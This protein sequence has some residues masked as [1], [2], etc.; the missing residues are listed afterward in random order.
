[1]ALYQ[2]F[3]GQSSFLVGVMESSDELYAAAA[4]L[5]MD[6]Q[7]FFSYSS[8]MTDEIIL[9]CIIHASNVTR[10][11]YPAMSES[12]TLAESFLTMLPSLNPLSAHAIVSSV[13]VLIEFLESSH[14][15]RA[16]AVQKYQIS[17]ES[18]SLLNACF[19]Y[20][21]R[22]DC[23]SGTTEC[24][25]SVSSAPDSDSCP[26]KSASEMRKRK[27]IQ[28]TL[29]V[30][31][32]VDELFHLDTSKLF[33]EGRETSRRMSNPNDTWLSE[34]PDVFNKVGKSSLSFENESF[35]QKS[36]SNINFKVTPSRM[37]KPCGSNMSESRVM[38][39]ERDNNVLPADDALFCRNQ[40]LESR[41]TN[42]FDMWNSMNSENFIQNFI[43]EVIDIDDEH[44]GAEDSSATV[45]RGL[46]YLKS[47]MERNSPLVF[48]KT[49]RKLSFDN[50]SLP[51]FPR[52][53]E[54]DYDTDGFISTN[55]DRKSLGGQQHF[56][57]QF[58]QNSDKE[59]NV[60]EN[61]PSEHQNYLLKEE[62]LPK[63]VG[64]SYKYS[65]MENNMPRYV[66]TPL[67]NA[68]QFSQPHQGSPWTIEFLNRV[69]EKSKLRQKSLPRDLSGPPLGYKGNISKLTKRRSPSILEFFKY[70]KGS[71]PSKKVEQKRQKRTSQPSTPY[72]EKTL[73]SF[74]PEMTPIDKRARQVHNYHYYYS[75]YTI[76]I[77]TIV[78][79]KLDI[80][81][82][83][84]ECRLYLLQHLE[85]VD[86]VSWF[87]VI[88]MHLKDSSSS[89]Y[90]VTLGCK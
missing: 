6:L 13:G 12:E 53:D 10:G 25:S 84:I 22:E 78:F 74:L 1:M 68:I 15:D 33:S 79:L 54:I 21:E 3:E 43:G 8:E 26:T 73:P 35:P 71:N 46:S 80:K 5:G 36:R 87:G 55:N 76:L 28:S 31:L 48:S 37:S 61:M 41:T 57:E 14:T 58:F 30:D 56:K 85:A 18:I 9:S 82:T 47:D 32:P 34:G 90:D 49:A 16:R 23:K 20:G 42:K 7:L 19:K 83:L 44:L 89:T 51:T 52:A 66:S 70:Q 67:S 24:S 72:N 11:L 81:Q 38:S 4:S 77:A 50:N 75:Y 39:E 27:H 86:R 88:H 65:L 17:D 40:G 45:F 62:I 29:N 59:I 2:V 64:S 69:R 63:S 60:E